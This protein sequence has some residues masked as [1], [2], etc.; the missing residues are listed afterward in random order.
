MIGCKQTVAVKGHQSESTPL[1][2][3]VPQGS[4]LCPKKYCSYTRPLGNIL[5]KYNIGF[6]MYAD[7]TQLY[8]PINANDGDVQCAIDTLENCVCEDRK[9]MQIICLKLNDEKT[10]LIIF[11]TKGTSRN[12]INLKVNIGDHE[13]SS[14]EHVRNLGS[15]YWLVNVYGKTYK[16]HYPNCIYV[17]VWYWED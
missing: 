10:E 7:D 15:Y 16:L 5:R 13:V 14:K 11:S 9:W 12:F 17:H 3:G 6:H 1:R 4:V 8:V 2:Y